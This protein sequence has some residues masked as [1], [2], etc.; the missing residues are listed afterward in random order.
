MIIRLILL[1]ILLIGFNACHTT[2]SEAGRAYFRK[3]EHAK[4]VEPAEALLKRLKNDQE[5]RDITYGQIK[6]ARI[7]Q[8]TFLRNQL[9][10]AAIE[11]SASEEIIDAVKIMEA[12]YQEN[13]QAFLSACDQI[14][15]TE[16]GKT[17]IAIQ[18]N[19]LARENLN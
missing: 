19:Y 6:S 11:K 2:L 8:C 16:L 13:D 9:Y 17:F 1:T 15:F 5:L 3:G 4:G 7:V 14:A 18:N 10:V 12:A